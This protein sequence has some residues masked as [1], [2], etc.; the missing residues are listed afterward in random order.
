MKS[1]VP[2]ALALAVAWSMSTSALADGDPAKGAKLVKRCIACHTFEKG[3]KNKIGPNLFGVL[4]RKAGSAP[5]YKYSKSYSAAGAGGLVWNAEAVFEYLADPK[6]FMRKI[7]GNKKARSKM[8][9][10]LKK[11]KDRRDVVAHLESRK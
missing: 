6:K 11:D 2:F 5:G 1:A 7:T 9:F 3:G 8:V 4:G 10:K